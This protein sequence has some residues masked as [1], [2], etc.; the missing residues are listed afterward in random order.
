MP[1]L[2]AHVKAA[3]T[4][5]AAKNMTLTLKHQM[6]SVRIVIYLLNM[7]WNDFVLLRQKLVTGETMKAAIRNKWVKALRSG[8]YVQGK[9]HYV[10]TGKKYDAFCCLGVL[11]DI[12]EATWE[13]NSH[14]GG[15]EIDGANYLGD[16]LVPNGPGWDEQSR[17]AH[18]ND[19]GDSFKRIA[20]YIER[21]F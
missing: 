12:Q 16:A 6:K 15:Y 20:N 3:G 19:G 18:M 10:S 21:H 14:S 17:L 5:N 8:E 11:A 7:T 1:G 4:H 13:M 2:T 9:G